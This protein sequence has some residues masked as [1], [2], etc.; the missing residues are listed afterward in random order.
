MSLCC[1]PRSQGRG[2]QRNSPDGFFRCGRRW[3][4]TQP[5]R[6]WPFSRRNREVTHGGSE[7]VLPDQA[8]TMISPEQVYFPYVVVSSE[9]S[10]GLICEQKVQWAK[11]AAT[12]A[13]LGLRHPDPLL[14]MSLQKSVK[15]TQEQQ[16]EE[17]DPHIISTTVA[18]VHRSSDVPCRPAQSVATW[19]AGDLGPVDD[20]SWSPLPEPPRVWRRSRPPTPYRLRRSLL[21]T[22]PNF[23]RIPPLMLPRVQTP[24]PKLP[25]LTM[26]ESSLQQGAHVNRSE[27]NHLEPKEAELKAAP[28]PAQQTEP[29]PAPPEEHLEEPAAQA[30]LEADSE[31]EGCLTPVAFSPYEVLPGA[32]MEVGPA[33]TAPPDHTEARNQL[34]EEASDQ[35]ALTPPTQEELCLHTTSGPAQEPPVQSTVPSPSEGS[36]FPPLFDCFLL[37][38]VI[39]I[40]PFSPWP[41]R[42]AGLRADGSRAGPG[43]WSEAGALWQEPGQVLQ[44]ALQSAVAGPRVTRQMLHRPPD[45]RAAAGVTPGS[46][47]PPGL[48]RPID[49]LL[50]LALHVKRWKLPALSPGL[51]LEL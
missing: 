31:L 24:S 21:F 18:Q 50:C 3:V 35:P 10:L 37:F 23:P 44:R 14:V 9:T 12:R 30:D 8:T 13:R 6:L 16:L 36:I 11:T 40:F 25:R 49:P 41:Y 17:G 28:A 22:T 34:P 46:N 29:A 19:A 42:D 43:V 26:S 15:N 45:S 39:I 51:V 48:E 32:A 38:S 20:L 4:Q 2:N 7:V 1:L 27:P 5:R 47:T 33:S